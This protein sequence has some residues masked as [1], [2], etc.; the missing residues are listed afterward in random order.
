M[1]AYTRKRLTKVEAKVSFEIYYE[2]NSITKNQCGAST[3][4]RNDGI[5]SAVHVKML[6]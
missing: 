6:M 5:R 4:D 2:A 1:V 3:D